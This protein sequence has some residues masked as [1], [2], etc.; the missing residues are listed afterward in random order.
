MT[1]RL[2]GFAMVVLLLV[3]LFSATGCVRTFTADVD[4][5]VVLVQ[6]PWFFGH[7]GVE[8][9]PLKTGRVWGVTTTEGIE[10]VVQPQKFEEPFDDLMS[11]DNVPLDFHVVARMQVQ[12]SVELIS[13]YGQDWYKNN[14]QQQFR[15]F[16]RDSAKLY[17]MPELSVSQEAVQKLEQNVFEKLTKYF[18]GQLE[19]EGGH[20]FK[21]VFPVKVL[22]ITV[23]RVNP[24]EEVMNRFAETA[25]WQQQIKTEGQKKLAEDARAAAEASRAKADRAY[26]EERGLTVEQYLRLKQLETCGEGNC[27]FVIGQ[28]PVVIGG[29]GK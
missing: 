1:T 26:Q 5:E 23:G 27:T 2:N 8:P 17:S 21:S 7:G 16:V 10:V 9:T 12:N 6:K 15:N 13:T 22:D 18:N 29:G 19:V 11:R 4:K 25:A 3:V 20:A 28:V 24:P 14:V